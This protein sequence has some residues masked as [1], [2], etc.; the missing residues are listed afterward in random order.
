MK[1]FDI[2]KHCKAISILDS[3][4]FDYFKF[5]PSLSLTQHKFSDKDQRE[6][7]KRCRNY[8]TE[9]GGSYAEC[10]RA[11][12]RRQCEKFGIL[13]FWATANLSEVTPSAGQLSSEALA[14][15]KDLFDG[16]RESDC[17]RPC[18]ETTV[19]GTEISQVCTANNHSSLH[20]TLDQIITLY[21]S[22]FPGFGWV[23]L[24]TD[25]GG[26]LGLWLGLG[27]A[28]LVEIILKSISKN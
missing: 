13:P 10:D 21:D 18:R 12:V 26:S 22:D 9:A 6:Q 17:A 4:S 7:A 3:R 8:P 19:I 2:I 20:F 1:Q 23:S 11:F 27:V 24:L 15:L 16:T 14:E 5:L 25:L 28:Q